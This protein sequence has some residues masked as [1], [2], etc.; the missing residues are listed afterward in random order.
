MLSLDGLSAEAANER[1]AGWL[2]SQE[3]LPYC[4]GDMAYFVVEWAGPDAPGILGNFN[5]WGGSWRLE[6]EGELCTRLGV[7]DYWVLRKTFAED[8]RLEYVVRRG[9]EYDVDAL[10]PEKVFYFD[11]HHSVLKMPKFKPH[12]ALNGVAKAGAGKLETVLF[13]SVEF[14]EQREVVVYT[15]PAFELGRSYPLL[16]VGDGKAYLEM[17]SFPQILDWLISEGRIPPLVAAFSDPGNRHLEYRMSTKH[18]LHILEEVMPLMR[19]RFGAGRSAADTYLCGG[20]R[21]GL[22]VLDLA[23]SHPG[24]FAGCLAFAPAVEGTDFLALRARLDAGKTKLFLL[25]GDYD[26]W[27]EDGLA[28]ARILSARGWSLRKED[29]PHGHSIYSWRHYLP[30]GLEHL[31]APEP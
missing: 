14:R 16:I 7:S 28:T 2:S 18:R 25:V 21:G 6:N 12:E 27:R 29:I 15:P 20:S 8:A 19:D 5:D 23:T 13:E 1:L 26:S 17:G 22:M 24:S 3:T 9:E 30:M 11:R 31:M 4:E 10:N